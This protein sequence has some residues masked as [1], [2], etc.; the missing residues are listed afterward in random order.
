MPVN[1]SHGNGKQAIVGGKTKNYRLPKCPVSM[2]LAGKI[3]HS[4]AGAFASALG[5][6]PKPINGDISWHNDCPDESSHQ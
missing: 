2:G 3:M 5:H 4:M 1:G 6:R